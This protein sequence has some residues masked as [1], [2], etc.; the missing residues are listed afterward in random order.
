MSWRAVCNLFW[1]W[2]TKPIL[3]SFIMMSNVTCQ[4][5]AIVHVQS[6]SL[7]Y[8]IY[9]LLLLYIYYIIIYIIYLYIFNYIFRSW[10]VRWCMHMHNCIDLTC[11][12]W[13]FSLQTGAFFLQTGAT[14]AV[15]Q[16]S[17]MTKVS[18][19][20]RPKPVFTYAWCQSSLM[21]GVSLHLW[22]ASAIRTIKESHAIQCYSKWFVAKRPFPKQRFRNCKNKHYFFTR[23]RGVGVEMPQFSK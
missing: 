18:H 21:P 1:P 17:L 9:T 8:S 12:I 6:L 20:L 23:K 4:V 11:D 13:H 15:D 3:G 10:E 22:P 16:S 14:D 19:H 7:L 2:R 5:D